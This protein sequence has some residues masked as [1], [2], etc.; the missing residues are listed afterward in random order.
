MKGI[1]AAFIIL[2]IL[3]ALIFGTFV[4]SCLVYNSSLSSIDSNADYGYCVPEVDIET[5]WP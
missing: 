5:I 3:T 4:Y 1:K 2:A